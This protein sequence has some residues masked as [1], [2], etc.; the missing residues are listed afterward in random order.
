VGQ[1]RSPEAATIPVLDLGPCFAG[2]PGALETAAAK[3]RTALEGVGFFLIV[4]HGLEATSSR[5]RS[6]RP[7][8]FTRSRRRPSSRCA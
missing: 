1:L 5:A 4:N 7:G 2:A 6:P 8:A 3:L